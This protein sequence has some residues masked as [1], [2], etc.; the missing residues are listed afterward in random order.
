[1]N[2]QAY[3]EKNIEEYQNRFQMGRLCARVLAAHQLNEE[4]LKEV[5]NPPKLCDPFEAD[6]LKAVI[7]RLYTARD[8]KEKVLICGDYDADG[9][10]ATAI[11]YHALSKAGIACGYYIPNRF[12]E[13]YGLHPHTVEMAKEKG[14]TLLIT[15]DNGVKAY[16]AA[17]KAAELGLELIITDH[18]TVEGD[19]PVCSMFLH[20]QKMGKPFETLSGAGVAFELSRALIGEDDEMLILACVAAIGDVMPLW[21]ESRAI[22]RMGIAALNR[23]LGMAIQ[24]LANQMGTWDETKIS[25]QVVPKLNV[26]GRLAD[27]ANANMTVRYLLSQNRDELSKC[28]KQIGDLNELRKI[29]SEEMTHKAMN[30]VDDQYLFQVLHDD[31]FHEG[32][33]GLVAGKLANQLQKPVM[34]L[35]GTEHLRGSIRSYGNL[36]LNEFFQD[37]QPL[38]DAYGGHPKAAG[39]GFDRDALKQVQKFVNQK[40]DQLDIS[41]EEVREYLPLQDGNLTLSQVQELQRLKPFGEGFSPVLFAYRMK[42]DMKPKTMSEGKH[43]KWSND[44]LEVVKFNCANQIPA[45]KKRDDLM[46]YGTLSISAFRGNQKIS[47]MAEDIQ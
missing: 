31:S 33:T 6:G 22:V 40:M 20:P 25:F 24:K 15:V 37:G 19:L 4:Q 9:I 42:P 12:R 17:K 32:L 2:Y 3:E 10:C 1:M 11:A 5:L 16:E 14:Y 29:K 13:G 41:D 43:I 36:N 8:H 35:S 26:T 30:L 44:Q 46:F 38:F 28:S 27:M 18:H 39:L 23:G 21:Q 47:L 34:I 7:D 45:W